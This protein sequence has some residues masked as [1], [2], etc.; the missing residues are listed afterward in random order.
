MSLL[1]GADQ[2]STERA[3]FIVPCHGVAYGTRITK[4]SRDGSRMALRLRESWEGEMVRTVPSREAR[5]GEAAVVRE[6]GFAVSM[7]R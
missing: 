7:S 4:V 3:K 6:V 2:Y 1:S 5:R